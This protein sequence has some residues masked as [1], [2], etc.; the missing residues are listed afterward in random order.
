MVTS[1]FSIVGSLILYNIIIIIIV[2]MLGL[3]IALTQFFIMI[4]LVDADLE[5]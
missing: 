3:P 5:L 4:T 2:N 1:L